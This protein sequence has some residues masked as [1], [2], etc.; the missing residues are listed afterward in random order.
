MTMEHIYIL[1]TKKNFS[2]PINIPKIG[3]KIE[4]FDMNGNGFLELQ[5]WLSKI[6]L[7][8]RVESILTYY[9]SD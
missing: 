8:E 6:P 7:D 4:P 2:A 3:T 5:E 1:C 9:V